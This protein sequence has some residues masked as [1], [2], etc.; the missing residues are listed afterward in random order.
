[1]KIKFCGG[2]EEVTGANYLIES[3]GAK[4]LID[5]G[6]IQKENICEL[7]N[8]ENFPYDPKEIS[9]VLITHAHLDHIGRL[10]KLIYEGFK[11]EI[12]S[13]LPTKDLAR[14]ILLDANK[15]INEK[16]RGM[17]SEVEKIYNEE[18]IEKIFEKWRTVD[19]HK[20]LEN[21]GLKIEFF[22][23]GHILGSAFIKLEE[24][25]KRIV[26]SGDLGNID[27]ILKPCEDL[28][29]SD[30]LILESTYGDRLHEN[31]ENRKEILEDI[32]EETLKENRTLIIP[33]FALER[34]QEILYDIV[35][36]IENKKVPEIKIFLDS[37]L[38]IRI[39]RIYD[40]YTEYFNE[41]AKKFF[42]H[43]D[44][45]DLDYVEIIHKEEDFRRIVNYPKAKIII[46]SSGMLQGG[47]IVN[48]LKYFIEEEST[49]I[50]FVGY[51]AQGSLGRKILEGEKEV[52]LDGKKYS[53]KAKIEKILA[54][55][56]HKDQRAIIDWIFPQR[57]KIKKIFLVQGEEKA[58]TI[59]KSRIEDYLG[60]KVEIPTKNQEIVL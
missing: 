47:R 30:F 48:I 59:L 21:N 52:Y 34:S 56:G 27:P 15:V 58:K 9:F 57:F 25:D 23:A 3:K 4:F 10:P 36:L 33:A 38:A 19:Y 54:Y 17:H 55:S 32:I 45:E 2:T 46:S 7:E 18:N 5:C 8:F 44:L 6:L 40:K 49:T 39:F 53:V 26:F 14:E 60:I 43:R 20:I 41:S 50:L 51:Q 35:D 1:M 13:T 16:C 11:G 29:E 37:P 22:D 31:L 12:I 42:I 24:E 28:P